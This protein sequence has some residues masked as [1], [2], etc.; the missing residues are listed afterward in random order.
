MY[1]L[2]HKGYP[3]YFVPFLKPRHSVYSTCKSQTDGVF[4]EV[5]H[6]APSVNKSSKHF[7]FG[8]ICLMMYVQPLLSTHSERSSKP[9]SLHKHIHPN[10]SFS[11][12]LSVAP[13]LSM[14]QAHDYSSLFFFGLVHLESVFRWRL[15]AIKILLEL[16]YLF[17]CTNPL[18]QHKYSPSS[19]D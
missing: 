5:P 1:K 15:S 14:S 8:M 16:E 18:P 7:G 3:K 2:L 17:Y 10:F 4:L 11:Q 9:I 13:T 19:G 12:F 6:F